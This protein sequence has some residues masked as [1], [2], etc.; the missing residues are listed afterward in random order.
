MRIYESAKKLARKAY[1]AAALTASLGLTGCGGVGRYFENRGKDALDCFS[2]KIG[3]APTPVIGADVKATDLC[4]IAV[5]GGDDIAYGFGMDGRNVGYNLYDKWEPVWGIP[6]PQT[7]AAL[8]PEEYGDAWAATYIAG[9]QGKFSES[10]KIKAP[11]DIDK[12]LCL[13]NIS[14][15][16][17]NQIYGLRVEP[18]GEL[19]EIFLRK[20]VN[21]KKIKEPNVVYSEKR[22]VIGPAWSLLGFG[23]K[24]E[25]MIKYSKFI[26]EYPSYD[27]PSIKKTDLYDIF[28]PRDGFR[29]ED[30]AP[31]K[32]EALPGRKLINCLDVE[33][34]VM[35]VGLGVKAG[36][37]PG[38]LIDFVLGFTG[39]DL[40]GDDK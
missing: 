12:Y 25:F 28:R 8:F 11:R 21:D 5:L 40:A 31:A 1:L 37:K 6:F 17:M 35:V 7:R 23:N 4:W 24:K 13:R 3:A 19:E 36:F 9:M 38:E 15:E 26:E 18:V 20:F 29:V 30:I 16:N 32:A 10:S 33:A 39:L 14:D 22:N 2:F 27:N 34:G